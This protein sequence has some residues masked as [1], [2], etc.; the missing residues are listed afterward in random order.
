M[1]EAEMGGR[2]PSLP[3]GET[4][5][6][7]EIEVLADYLLARIIGRGAITREECGE[8]FGPNARFCADYPAK[9]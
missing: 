2:T 9:P 6:K 3:P 5:Q 1:T 8:N 4:L 7:R